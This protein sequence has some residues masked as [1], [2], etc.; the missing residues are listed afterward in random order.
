MNLNIFQWHSL[1]TRV[2]LF[3]LLIFVI[4]IWSLAFYASRML[5]ADMER[6]LGEQQYTAVSFVADSVN[7]QI[8][9]RLKG[10]ERIAAT[11]SPSTLANSTA[12]QSFLDGRVVLQLL[13]NRGLMAFRADGTAT[14]DTPTIAS[15]TGVNYMDREHI[16]A[17]LKEGKP[18]VSRP[19]LG[20][21]GS[22]PFFTIVVPVRDAQG[23]VIGALA[24]VTDL[25]KP[26]FLDIIADSR[27][28]KTGGYLLVAPQYRQ[29]VTATDKSRIMETLPA[30]GI[31]PLID[32]FIQ[33]YH[34]SSVL[35]NSLGQE[36]LVSSK[37]IPTAGWYMAAALPTAEAF[38][39]IL[40][41]QQR[42]VLATLLLT[43][44]AGLLTRWMLQRQLA[45][46]L[47]AVTAL[48]QLAET[49][50]SP[51]PLPIS[52]QDEIGKL[53]G[54]FN[55]LLQTLG[56][57]EKALQLSEA[58][59][60]TLV[61]KLPVG[62]LLQSPSSE[63][64]MNNQVALDL[65]GIT[66]AQLLG[67]TSFD[68]SWNVIHED[69]TPFP[70]ATHPVPQA[71]AT[72]AAVR[73]VVMGVYRPIQQ[74]RVWLL[75]TAE[76]Q[77]D[78]DGSVQQVVCT[79]IDI[80]LRMQ[81]RAALQKNEEKLRTI[82]DNVNAVLFLKDLNGRYLYA[83]RQYE[84][85]LHIPRTS[86]EGKT[87]HDFFP[88][89]TVAA[90]IRNDQQVMATGL[91]IEV[92]EQVLQDDGIHTYLSVK[93]PVRDANGTIYAVC[94][95]ATDITQRKRAETE[96]RIA[97]TAFESQES[98]MITDASSVI[99][100][101]NRAF[102]ESTGYTSEDAVGQT[103]RLLSSGRHTA[104]FFQT[105]WQTIHRTGSWQGEVWDRRKNGEIYPKWL[106]ISAVKD[107]H[108][109]VTNY[110]GTH[111]DITERKLAQDKIEELAF[112]DPLTHL[113]NRTLLMDRLKQAMIVGNRNGSCGAAM[114]I[115]LDHFKT[116]N[117][118]LG[119]DRG[120]LLLEIVAQRL[121]SSVREGDT[122]ARLGGDEF[123][124]VLENLSKDPQE[125]ATQ[126]KALGEKI[127][128]VL[129][130]SYQLGTVEHHCTASM[131]A[132]LFIGQE[133]A[134]D[135]V[136][137][138]ADLAMYKSKET[139]RNALHFFD[140]EMQ[141]VVMERADLEKNLRQAIRDQ[142]FVLHYQAQVVSDGRMTGAEVL[143]RWQHPERGMVP[144][145]NFI[146]L[147]EETGLILPLGQWVLETACAQLARWATQPAMSHLTVAVNVS[148]KQFHQPDFVAQVMTALAQTGAN[149]SRL[150][151]ELTE[152]LL[153]NNVQDIIE[154][155][156]TLKAMGVG[157]SLDD[158]GTGY[159]SLTYLKRLPL[160]QLKIDKSFVRDILIDPNDAA[161]ARTIVALAQSLGLGVIAEGVETQAQRD[162]LAN[163][164]CH[165]YQG[166]YF[167][168]PL[169][170]EDFEALAKQT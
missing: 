80:T 68:P 32:R 91:P 37:S 88:P 110:V 125:A 11:L 39:P 66:E 69:G 4:G 108:G 119:H 43:L 45:P 116:L 130:Q 33:G 86:I 34:G 140:P 126:T 99:L 24:G 132:T 1:K 159:S 87:D 13:F 120:D 21:T 138:Q 23:K 118:T 44:L 149:P 150:K 51:Q 113:P 38:S 63:I 165:A 95:I 102:T 101:I 73:N 50:Q 106:N 151:L 27:Y 72:R 158:F 92:E 5:R 59:Y 78:L 83:N 58:N 94:G 30:P 85:L 141:K 139:G 154:K 31:N 142:Q 41:M 56:E 114:F 77:L 35:T 17:A 137:K 7:Q 166:Y 135:D 146:S 145:D 28:G 144:P 153:V 112:F 117:D 133:T 104:D 148:A 64:V 6:L 3:T 156:H 70:S 16:A 136:L 25:G 18:G 168:R 105:M 52:R 96:L 127:L 62:V 169:A 2:T 29:I 128:V 60:R 89:E 54:G 107:E 22:G 8:D 81:A 10:L 12:L 157:F 53:I 84:A 71:V 19:V 152:S 67:K 164:G 161:I 57:R 103:P 48:T 124:I 111:T 143:V 49:K 61:E 123:V 9:E 36:V 162:F 115:D 100:R 14:A 40:A 15:R 79:F 47:A 46:M 167:S 42:V 134:I 131:G 20:K 163:A 170:L 160:D 82:T 76:P 97:A 26:N 129:N 98:M 75:V 65:L 93:L 74:N 121:T 122:V 90:F 109:V 55:R 147:A 155:I